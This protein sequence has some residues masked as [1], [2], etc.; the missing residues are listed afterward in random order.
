[1]RF[2]VLLIMLLLSSVS[3][4]A[5]CKT[6]SMLA[7]TPDSKLIDNKD[8]TITDLQT[9]LMWKKC[10]EGFSGESCGTGSIASFT[11]QQALEQPDIVNNNGGFAGYYDWRL[12]N[13][14][15]LLSI[16]E[17]QCWWPAINRNRFPDTPNSYFWSASPHEL[18]YAWSIDFGRG[19]LSFD[20]RDTSYYV[21]LVRGGN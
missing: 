1:M 17:E 9:G 8:N 4:Y 21:R 15:E 14:K 7:S 13:I 19:D 5:Q 11:W 18:S 2:C 16:V 10:S 6:D 12:P 3:V 20:T